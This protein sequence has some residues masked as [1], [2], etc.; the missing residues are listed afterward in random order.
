MSTPL[1]SPSPITSRVSVHDRLVTLPPGVPDLTLGWE[2]VRW[3]SKYLRHPNGPRAGQRW[4]FIDSQLL[5]LLHWYAVDEDGRWLYRHAARRLAK[6]SGK[7]PFAGLLALVELCAPVRLRDFDADAPGGCIGRP[8]D[9]PLVEI[10]ATA[11]SQTANTMRM[12]RAFASKGSRVVSDYNLD[13]G[14]TVIYSPNG[15]ALK[16][17]TSSALAAEGSET[18]F[19]VGD[20]TEHW[21][22]SNGGQELSATI[23]RNVRKSGSRWLET[24]NAWEPG[25]G[26]VAESTW[27]AYVAQEEG[28]TRGE[29]R[30]LYDTRIA[31]PDTD[32]ADEG[33]LRRGLEQVYGDCW[34]VNL[35]DII[36]GVWDPRTRPDVARR[37]YLNQPT[38]HMDS[39]VTPQQWS[40]CARPEIVVEPG[41]YIVAF[42]DGSRS[43]DATA[44]IGCRMS[45]GHVFT[46]G[47]WEPN[48]EDVVPVEQVDATVA[49][50]F[51]TW[52]V[53]A[54][55]ADVREWES[56]TKVSWPAEH[57]EGLVLWAEK[58]T[59]KDPQPIAWDM[60]GHLTEFTKAAELCAAE[61]EDQSITHD[62][63]PR[64][65]R[66]VMN[67]RRRVN[68]YGVSIG[69]E[70]RGS[71]KK[72]DAAVCV[73][74]VRMV[75]RYVQATGWEPRRPKR[76]PARLR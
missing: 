49:R 15:G 24:S 43:D 9:M 56:F 69:K 75:R 22:V 10:A 21:T 5:F 46:I 39:W 6:G 4:E 1:L 18:T 52:K 44:L 59:T 16:V 11:E 14:K 29:S 70:S 63:D 33:S 76:A 2:A 38:A 36:E 61:I 64:V 50:M 48:G 57:G 51:A 20:E 72:I 41:D 32:M 3:A 37:F 17:I 12:V 55:Y 53:L 26:S 66:H 58:A 25:A 65:A 27:D 31:P 62:G 68:R 28:R 73:V 60:R 19:A 35:N 74:G 54:F 67:A 13:V 23:D 47:V 71:Q 45:D 40:A 7:S 42:F 34:W 8:V 30:I